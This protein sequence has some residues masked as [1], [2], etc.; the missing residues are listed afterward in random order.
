M[1]GFKNLEK[2]TLG[3]V[4]QNYQEVLELLKEKKDINTPI[5]MNVSNRKFQNVPFSDR[6]NGKV[7]EFAKE[8]TS[9]LNSENTAHRYQAKASAMN[10][11]IIISFF[12]KQVEECRDLPSTNLND[13]VLKVG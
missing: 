12:K 8:I 9:I 2:V 1:L 6:V 3:E 5:K 11:T 10:D 13:T 7:I 4:V